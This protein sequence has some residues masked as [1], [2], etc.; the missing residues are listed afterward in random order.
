MDGEV[1]QFRVDSCAALER[2]FGPRRG[3]EEELDD[4]FRD[5]AAALQR[6]TN[7][8]LLGV[9]RRLKAQTGSKNLC[10]A[11]GVALNCVANRLLLEE[12]GFEDLFV[13][14]LHLV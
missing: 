10:L 11:G 3:G 2:L 7:T 14:D 9:V 4:R 1:L 12:G 5:I 13:V 8:A 6:V